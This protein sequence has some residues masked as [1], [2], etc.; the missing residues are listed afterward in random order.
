MQ[1]YSESLLLC[2]VYRLIC[3]VGDEAEPV[4][5]EE[6]LS[7][8]LRVYCVIVL[9]VVSELSHCSLEYGNNDDTWAWCYLDI[10]EALAK[11]KEL[12]MK[13]EPRERLIVGTV[14]CVQN[15]KTGK[16]LEL[17]PEED[18]LEI[19]GVKYGEYKTELFRLEPED[20]LLWPRRDS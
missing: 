17:V 3:V 4:A 20:F 18:D 11:A 1:S 2:R 13:I 19:G 9:W 14:Y 6:P 8:I 7:L 5:P 12:L 16:L 15:L 10:R